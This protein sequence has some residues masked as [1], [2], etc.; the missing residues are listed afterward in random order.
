M[1]SAAYLPP[2][3]GSDSNSREQADG[4]EET[5]HKVGTIVFGEPADGCWLVVHQHISPLRG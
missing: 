5:A 2:A 4:G 1:G 3:T